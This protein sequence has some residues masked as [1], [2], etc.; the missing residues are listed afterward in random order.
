MVQSAAG[1][2]IG[3]WCRWWRAI[4]VGAGVVLVRLPNQAGGSTSWRKTGTTS[5]EECN[6]E[7]HAGHQSESNG[8]VS[9]AFFFKGSFC[10]RSNPTVTAR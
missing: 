9:F 1:S 3:T 6:G 4:A 7:A 5:A 8:A 2:S 10:L